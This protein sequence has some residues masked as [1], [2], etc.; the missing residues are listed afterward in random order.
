MEIRYILLLVLNSQPQRPSEILQALD[1]I[2]SGRTAGPCGGSRNLL[3]I[4][5]IDPDIRQK[6]AVLA[7]IPKCFEA[8]GLL[9]KENLI[10]EENGQFK[11]LHEGILAAAAVI[12]D[13]KK[14]RPINFMGVI[15]PLQRR[16]V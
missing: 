5:D 9:V 15:S 8:L 1:D 4:A 10:G 2:S 11:L 7:D 13:L 3:A 16:C 12:R 6:L 14:K